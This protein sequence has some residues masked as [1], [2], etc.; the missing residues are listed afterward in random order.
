MDDNFFWQPVNQPYKDQQPQFPAGDPLDG[1]SVPADFEQ[2]NINQQYIPKTVKQSKLV[3]QQPTEMEHL[4][5]EM[6]MASKPDAELPRQPPVLFVMTRQQKTAADFTYFQQNMQDSPQTLAIKQARLA[7]Q[8]MAQQ[9]LQADDFFGG[10]AKPAPPKRHD[11][12]GNVI[13]DR[14]PQLRGPSKGEDPD[15]LSDLDPETAKRRLSELRRK[16]QSGYDSEG[17]V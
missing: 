13:H 7:Q 9:N 8:Q 5:I 15:N 12:H 2:V 1:R 6:S 3:V 16:H 10:A 14:V 4:S 17:N 11:R